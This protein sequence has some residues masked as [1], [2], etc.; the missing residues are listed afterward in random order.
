[1][2]S[3]Q[4][5]KAPDYWVHEI[6]LVIKIYEEHSQVHDARLRDPERGAAA[7]APPTPAPDRAPARV[8]ATSVTTPVNGV[9]AR[10]FL[11]S[12]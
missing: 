5:Y 10:F 11:L 3:G 12:M 1:M 6:Q 9:G 8:R 7:Y 4:D 2:G